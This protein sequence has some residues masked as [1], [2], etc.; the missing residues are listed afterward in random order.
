MDESVNYITTDHFNYH[1]DP[2][3]HELR[4]Y[5]PNTDLRCHYWM[6]T[7]CSNSVN[8][9]GLDVVPNWEESWANLFKLQTSN[10][11]IHTFTHTYVHT[12]TNSHIHTYTNSHIHTFT[13]THTYIHAHVHTYKCTCVCI[14]HWNAYIRRLTFINKFVDVSMAS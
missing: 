4:S 7:Q 14:I 13:N 10:T 2:K 9:Y 5:F 1:Q 11:Y 3:C 12:Y 6:Y 8:L